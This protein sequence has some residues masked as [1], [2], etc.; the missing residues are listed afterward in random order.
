[1]PQ[2][3]NPADQPLA[4]QDLGS[5]LTLNQG[6][7]AINAENESFERYGLGLSASGGWITDFLGT[8]TNHQGAAYML[9]GAS[10]GLKL[11][12]EQDPVLSAVS[13]AVLHVSA[14]HATS[15]IFRR[16]YSRV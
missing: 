15:T 3:T 12:S 9:F 7:N 6:V 16:A 13:A 4:G 11:N 1:M 2:T 8:Q 10:G 5:S 14:I